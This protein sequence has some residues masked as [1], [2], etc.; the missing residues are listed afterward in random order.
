MAL[1]DHELRRLREKATAN[2]RGLVWPQVQEGEN[3]PAYTGRAILPRLVELISELNHPGLK[4]R[5]DG[6]E[7]PD[8]VTLGNLTFTPDVA[9]S[10]NH[11]RELAVECKFVS[12]G[13][14]NNRI[15]TALGQASLYKTLGYKASM[16]VLV[17]KGKI[18]AL[19]GGTTESLEKLGSSLGI[20]VIFAKPRGTLDYSK[21]Q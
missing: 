15:A 11:S 9:F 21:N 4:L 3:E 1:S 18:H 19:D 13:A 10:H 5:G 16:L 7:A 8:Y 12:S 20:D 14:V 2:L 6:F 17:G